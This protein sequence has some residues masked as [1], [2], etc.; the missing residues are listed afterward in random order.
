MVDSGL[1]TA[2]T[3][4]PSFPPLHVERLDP[5]GTKAALSSLVENITGVDAAVLTFARDVGDV[6]IARRMSW[7]SSRHTTRLEDEAYCLMG[8]FGVNMSTLYGEG[9]DAFRRLQEEIIKRSS[10]H[11]LFAWGATFP[12]NS[13]SL[14]Q[15][16]PDALEAEN[17][18]FAPSPAAFVGSAGVFSVSPDKVMNAVAECLSIAPNSVRHAGELTITSYGVRCQ[19]LVIHEKVYHLAVLACQN[20]FGQPIGL[21]LRQRQS[22]DGSLPQYY[23]GASFL[24][25]SRSTASGRMEPRR[26]RVY[27]MMTIH[28]RTRQTLITLTQLHMGRRSPL[29]ANEDEWSKEVYIIHR[30]PHVAHPWMRLFTS[31]PNKFFVPTW[32][33]VEPGRFGFKRLPD[34]ERKPSTRPGDP[35]TAFQTMTFTNP[36]HKESFTIEL[37]RCTIAS[38]LWATV[39]ITPA[40]YM[41]HIPAYT[42]S[43]TLRDNHHEAQGTH[44]FTPPAHVA[45]A[46]PQPLPSDSFPQAAPFLTPQIWHVGIMPGPG[47]TSRS[48]PSQSQAFCSTYHIGSWETGSM[49]FGDKDRTVQLTFTRWPSAD[50]YCIEVRPQ[51]RVYERMLAQSLASRGEGPK[52]APVIQTDDTD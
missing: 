34:G 35:S 12:L 26:S 15:V 32:I 36:P 42:T 50:S 10:D 9:R 13:V 39:S 7:A 31:E 52:P 8:L 19:L 4:R 29:S 22:S 47:G 44:A 23:V 43:H 45:F 1:D 20:E 14:G 16:I 5:L 41:Y 40:S 24:D 2:G 37:G 25:D 46:S 18:L 48:R 21:L 49:C 38:K 3:H 33:G 30:P 17:F 6:S 11:S 51:G 27:R 28:P